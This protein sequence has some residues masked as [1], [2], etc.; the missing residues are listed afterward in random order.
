MLIIQQRLFHPNYG[1]QYIFM[2]NEDGEPLPSLKMLWA[3]G[4]TFG[5]WRIVK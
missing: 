2:W 1:Q 5:W 4:I 3:M